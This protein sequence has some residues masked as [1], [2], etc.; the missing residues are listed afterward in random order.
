MF[1]LNK[2][3]SCIMKKGMVVLKLKGKHKLLQVVKKKVTS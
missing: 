3:N 1:T 2:S